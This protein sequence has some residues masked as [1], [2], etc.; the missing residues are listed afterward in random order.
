MKIYI[1]YINT[2]PHPPKVEILCI[3]TPFSS[4]QQTRRRSM[5]ILHVYIYIYICPKE[6]VFK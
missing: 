1:T 4:I 6:E 3:G 5:H 2:S